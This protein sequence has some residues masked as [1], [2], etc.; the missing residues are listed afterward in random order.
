MD[1]AG[2]HGAISIYRAQRWVASWRAPAMV[3]E[4]DRF[5]RHEERHRALF[6]AELARRGIRRCP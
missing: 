4:I 1:H 3:D 2:E 6:A 5:L